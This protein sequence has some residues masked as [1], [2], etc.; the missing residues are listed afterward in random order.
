MF[1]SRIAGRINH[2][3]FSVCDVLLQLQLIQATLSKNLLVNPA[4]FLCHQTLMCSSRRHK[5]FVCPCT[6]TK[7]WHRQEGQSCI[8]CLEGMPR[9][10]C[11]VQ[12]V[13]QGAGG[14]CPQPPGDVVDAQMHLQELLFGGWA[15]CGSSGRLFPPLCP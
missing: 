3:G 15:Q 4:S 10:C 6:G 5:E 11:P 2:G 7:P 13:K 14:K 9:S 12:W 1:D 8:Q